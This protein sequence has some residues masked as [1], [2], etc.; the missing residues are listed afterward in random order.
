MSGNPTRFLV[1]LLYTLAFVAVLVVL[2]LTAVSGGMATYIK[3]NPDK[4]NSSSY[5]YNFPS[6]ILPNKYW[7]DFVGYPESFSNIA[8]YVP[9]ITTPTKNGSVNKKITLATDCM[10]LC[11]AQDDCTGFL[12][13]K[14]SNTCTLYSSVDKL[15]PVPLS[16]VVYSLKGKEPASMYVSNTGKMPKPFTPM[17]LTKAMTFNPGDVRIKSVTG[18]A[19][20]V[21]VETFD[22]HGLDTS[23]TIILYNIPT[24]VFNSGASAS[25]PYPVSTTGLTVPT[26]TTITFPSTYTG[27]STWTQNDTNP[28]RI[29]VSSTQSQA[30][31][32]ILFTT[33][34]AHTFTTGQTVAITGMTGATLFNNVF[35]ITDTTDTTFTVSISGT[36]LAQSATGGSALITSALKPFKLTT[37]QN[38]RDCASVCTSNASCLA[39]TFDS[40]SLTCSQI[41][42]GIDDTIT[43]SPTTLS[44]YTTGTPVLADS[45][46]YY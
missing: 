18:A 42:F 20:T 45:E 40:S 28:A 43:A 1:P 15:F 39:F 41:T 14:G 44:L 8:G 33:S 46:T 10:L 21:T 38:A 16:N 36:S 17:N 11:A 34:T 19:G 13:D 32:S 9:T 23:S 12:L 4:G 25:V 26:T 22:P 29:C 6:W 7:H 27:T 37:G 2:Y 24:I 31:R 30:A 3:Y 35:T 5:F